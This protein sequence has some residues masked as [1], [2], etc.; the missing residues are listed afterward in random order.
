MRAEHLPS[1]H[2]TSTRS[3]P[4][5]APPP[6]PPGPLPTYPAARTVSA[7]PRRDQVSRPRCSLV[8]GCSSPRS[9]Q[10]RRE[11]R[12]GRGRMVCGA[13]QES[14]SGG[15]R[16]VCPRWVTIPE[17][18]AAGTRKRGGG[19]ATGPEGRKESPPG[20]SL[21]QGSEEPQD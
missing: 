8:S 19:A 20:S 5:P 15:F 13:P 3:R 21:P 9:W 11:V 4:S 7:E 16:K 6:A 14:L 10:V 1:S 2:Q 17:P 12:A 18:R